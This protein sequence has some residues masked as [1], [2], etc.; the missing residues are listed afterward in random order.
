MPLLSLLSVIDD[1]KCVLILCKVKRMK[2]QSLNM[3]GI[4]MSMSQLDWE[5]TASPLLSLGGWGGHS[6]PLP[7]CG[8]SPAR[9]YARPWRA[10]IYAGGGHI[11][12]CIYAGH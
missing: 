3:Y 4:L 12:T 6:P 9:P 7:P 1:R 2:E 5:G 8:A 10:Y 11:H